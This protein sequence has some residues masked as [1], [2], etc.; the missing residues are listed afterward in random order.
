MMNFKYIHPNGGSH[1]KTITTGP[2][3]TWEEWCR[4]VAALEAKAELA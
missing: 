4:L 3:M 2:T 1:E